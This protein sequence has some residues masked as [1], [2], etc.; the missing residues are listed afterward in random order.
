MDKTTTAATRLS[1][2]QIAPKHQ[3]AWDSTSLSA[4]KRCPRY[5]QYAIVEGY[6]GRVAN[7]HLSFGSFYNDSLVTYNKGR[8]AGL[9]HEEALLGAVRYALT[10]TWNE[11]LGRPWTSDLPTKTRETLLRSVIWYLEQFAEDSCVTDIMPDGKSAVELSFRL[12]LEVDS[13]LTGEPYLLCG[14]LDRKVTFCGYSWIMDWKTSQR[15]LDE[16]YFAEYTPN[17]QV[18][19]YSFAGR[20]VGGEQIKGVIIDAA[21]L[22]VTF[23][24][25]QRSQIGRTDAQLEEWLHDS[26]TF[27]R[28]NETYVANNYWPQ[29]DAVCGLYGGCPFRP[30]CSLTPDLRQQHIDALFSKRMW[31]PLLMREV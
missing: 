13:Q 21:Q 24:R 9:A 23:T 3:L 25:F 5:Y 30:I 14:Y 27:I 10:V 15:A 28:Q 29:N 17:T 16:K 22:G 1:F 7:V 12:H 6:T 11:N 26:L 18:S 19:Q 4:L 20:I 2:S 8:A 31:D